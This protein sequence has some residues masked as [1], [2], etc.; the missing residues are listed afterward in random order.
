MAKIGFVGLGHMGLPMAINLVKAGH[1]VTGYDVQQSALHHF[2]QAGGLVA[3][4]TLEVAREQDILITMLQNGQQVLNVC[5][6]NNGLFQAAKKGALFIDCSTID[7]NSS[8][9]LHHLA[10]QHQLQV[11]DAPVSGGVA[12]AGAATLTFMVGGEENAF[13]AAQPILATMGQKIIH[14]GTAGSGQAAKICN[15]MILGIS[16]IA[17][18]EAFTLAEHLQLSPQKLFEVVTNASGQC[19]AMSKYAPVPGVLENVPANNDYKPG[20]AAAMMLKDLLLSQD[21]A[22]SVNV[23]TPLGAKATTIYQHFIDQGLGDSDFSAIIKMISQGE[24]V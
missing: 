4:N 1:Q 21:S 20:F 22:R 8:R 15:N 9:E 10:K 7:V 17:I 6:G 2:S 18:S 14:T 24:E 11:V 3:Q 13:H 23:S 16:M 19:W 12:G 5:H